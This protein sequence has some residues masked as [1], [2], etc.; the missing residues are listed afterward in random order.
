MV[1]NIEFDRK[2]YSSSPRKY[3]QKRAEI[4][5]YQNW[6]SNQIITLSHLLSNHQLNIEDLT[7]TKKWY[8]NWLIW[9]KYFCISK[10]NKENLYNILLLITLKWFLCFFLS[11]CL[12]SNF[13]LDLN[14]YW[15]EHN[16]TSVSWNYIMHAWV[17]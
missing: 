17:N 7:R 15:T 8:T 13:I 4:I 9:L 1:I 12:T 11:I 16:V 2:V 3:N 5:W 6:T 10:N 14:K